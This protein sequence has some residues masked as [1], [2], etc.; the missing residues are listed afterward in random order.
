MG[1]APPFEVLMI[2]NPHYKRVTLRRNSKGQYILA[3]QA[4]RE[5]AGEFGFAVGDTIVVSSLGN[6]KLK[7]TISEIAGLH[8]L[9][10][11]PI[12]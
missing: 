1:S 2:N 3:G 12:P 11:P 7:M 10:L 6:S 4:W 9:P 8:V 5:F